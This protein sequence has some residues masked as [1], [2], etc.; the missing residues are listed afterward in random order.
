MIAGFAVSRLAGSREVV[1]RSGAVGL[2]PSIQKGLFKTRMFLGFSVPLRKAQLSQLSK[3]FS[4]RPLDLSRMRTVLVQGHLES[5]SCRLSDSDIPLILPGLGNVVGRCF[6]PLG[7]HLPSFSGTGTT[8]CT[9]HFSRFD[10]QVS[11]SLPIHKTNRL[12]RWWDS[13]TYG[14]AA[15]RL[16]RD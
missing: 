14:F 9:Q 1:P 16:L 11:L 10:S 5:P 7:M 4:P 2:H 12:R 13:P 6:S 15:S 3:G 8:L